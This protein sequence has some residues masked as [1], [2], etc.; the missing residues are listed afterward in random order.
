MSGFEQP[1]VLRGEIFCSPWCGCRCTLAAYTAACAAANV[2]A[3]RL[4][5]GWE[6]VVWE[7]GTW[8][9]RV[10]KGCV[11][12]RPERGTDRWSAWIEPK[13]AVGGGQTKTA[14]Q[15]IEY[16]DTPEDALGFATQAART[17][18]AHLAQA[19]EDV[20]A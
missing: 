17:H 15:F 11:T 16:A 13:I 10:T 3:A 19:L 4:G 8:H 9:Y 2:L 14:V 7:N 20:L 12:V 6:P 18:M 1:P 5:E